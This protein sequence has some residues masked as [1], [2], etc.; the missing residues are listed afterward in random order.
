MSVSATWK[1][2]GDKIQQRITIHEIYESQQLSKLLQEIASI[3][4]DIN[5][6]LPDGRTPILHRGKQGGGKGIK[7]GTPLHPGNR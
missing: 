1:K 4:L 3:G 5:Q 7:T 6:F 2:D